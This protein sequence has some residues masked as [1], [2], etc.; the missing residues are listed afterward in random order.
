[1][2]GL[3]AVLTAIKDEYS[4]LIKR[5]R[6]GREIL[7]AVVC[8]TSFIFALQNI[9]NVSGVRSSCVWPGLKKI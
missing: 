8:G 5:H 3:E 2:G 4:W 7:T 6:Y 9:T 1:M